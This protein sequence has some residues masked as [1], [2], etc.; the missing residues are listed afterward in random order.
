MYANTKAL[1]AVLL[2]MSC[3]TEAM[4][5]NTS[6]M[7]GTAMALYAACISNVW[8]YNLNVKP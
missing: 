3:N 1:Q 5:A 2:T 6:L 8:Q 4:Y 7:Y